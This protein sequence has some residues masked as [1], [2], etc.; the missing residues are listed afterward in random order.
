MKPVSRA[1]MVYEE[2]S[3]VKLAKEKWDFAETVRVSDPLAIGI[4][5]LK[6]S[7]LTKPKK[8]RQSHKRQ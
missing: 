3:I 6:R 5:G 2:L 7:P 4:E 1:A 8:K